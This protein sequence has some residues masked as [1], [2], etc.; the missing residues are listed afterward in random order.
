MMTGF[1]IFALT[2]A[3]LMA[4]PALALDAMP[5]LAG[6][7]TQ[8]IL[9][10]ASTDGAAA[11]TMVTR[12]GDRAMAAIQDKTQSEAQK[13][14]TFHQLLG[15]NFDMSTIGRFAMG[16]FW[17][18]A[19]PEQQQEYLRLYQKMVIDVYTSRFNRY[20][21]Q[22]FT[23]TGNRVDESGDI[24]VNSQITG[25]GSP[26]TVDWRVRAKGGVYRVI[27]VMVEGVSMAGTQ[28]NDFAGIIQQGGGTVDAL[29]DYLRKGGTSDVED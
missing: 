16:R 7:A 19:T 10:V 4:G 18:V 11:Q 25:D 15:Q 21:G 14:Q 28:R 8:Q 24:V 22:K 5:M 2:L 20:S 27:D 26:V 29:L 12:L 9:P 17:K 23:V 1:R 13:K 6:S 3:L